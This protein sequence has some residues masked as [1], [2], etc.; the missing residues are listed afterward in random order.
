MED[1]FPRDQRVG[2]GLGLIQ[3]HD[4]YCALYFYYISIISDHQ[5]LLDPRGWGPLLWGNRLPK[6]MGL[7]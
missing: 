3:A 7:R 2:D 6:F 5:A 4:I 1:S